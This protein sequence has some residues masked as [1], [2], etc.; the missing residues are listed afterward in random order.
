MGAMTL[1][2]GAKPA[3]L[4]RPFV[5]A[6]SV[7]AGA[8]S[9]SSGDAFKHRAL[10]MSRRTAATSLDQ[11]AAGDEWVWQGKH[12]DGSTVNAQ[13]VD[14]VALLNINFRRF[15]VEYRQSGGAWQTLPGADKTGADF[16]DDHLIIAL[17]ESAAVTADEWRVRATHTQGGDVEKSMGMFIVTSLIFQSSR[18]TSDLSPKR[19]D[20]V[21]TVVMADGSK[22]ETILLH[23]DGDF[24]FYATPLLF[25][26]VPKTEETSFQD[27]KGTFF[28]FVP[29]PGK[30]PNEWRYCR[31]V[32]NTM[33]SQPFAMGAD[34]TRYRVAFQLEEVGAP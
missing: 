8:I 27:L 3:F 32:P 17:D 15:I 14:T 12:Y 13:P 30:F 31:V 18:G 23:N 33:D 16:T 34:E 28:L 4:T 10:D 5:N 6:D 26:A 25:H 20:T 29:Q 19:N 9:V 21:V 22:D 24:D 1:T 2:A 7:A 11:A